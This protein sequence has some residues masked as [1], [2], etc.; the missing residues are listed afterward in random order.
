MI[1]LHQQRN[2]DSLLVPCSKIPVV[3]IIRKSN[4][5]M[6]LSIEKICAFCRKPPSKDETGN[7]IKLKT[8]SRCKSVCY[9]DIECQKKHWKVHKKVCGISSPPSSQSPAAQASITK[10]PSTSNNIRTKQKHRSID[11]IHQLVTRRFK[12]LRKQGAPVQEAMKRAREEFQ[13]SEDRYL[14]PASKGE[15]VHTFA[16]I[17]GIL[18]AILI[19]SLMLVFNQES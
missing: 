11:P 8:C 6:P 19:I 5:K 16:T 15:F 18:F 4:V 12:E 13:T 17:V 2:L 10:R 1:C 7:C 3:N 9:H 14:D